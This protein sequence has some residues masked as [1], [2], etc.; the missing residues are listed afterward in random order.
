MPLTGFDMHHVAHCYIPFFGFRCHLTL[1]RRDHENL[2]AVMD[3]PSGRRADAEVDDVT[4]EIFRLPVADNRLSRPAYRPAGPAGNRG[5]SIH[6]VFRQ[7]VDFQYTH[8][9]P[10]LCTG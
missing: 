5:G 6:W 2:I 10:P 9:G 8:S 3:M 4:A 1:A 7:T